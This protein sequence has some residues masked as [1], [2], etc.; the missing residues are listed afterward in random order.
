MQLL[1]TDYSGSD[2]VNE[3]VRRPQPRVYHSVCPLQQPITAWTQFCKK[4]T[5]PTSLMT[6]NTSA[7]RTR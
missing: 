1:N 2:L 7:S 5:T 4:F 6:C 3:D